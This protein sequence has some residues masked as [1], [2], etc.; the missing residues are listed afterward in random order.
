MIKPDLVPAFCKYF[1]IDLPK[2]SRINLERYHLMRKEWNQWFGHAEQT[3]ER[4]RDFYAQSEFLPYGLLHCAMGEI[5]ASE[6]AWVR[7]QLEK[8]EAKSILDY[9]CG[10]AIATGPLS[11]EM[12]VTLADI[13]GRHWPLVKQLYPA[14]QF[15]EIGG[16][17]ESLGKYDAVVCREVFEHCKQPLETAK[18]VLGCVAE[19][20][21]AILSWTFSGS[22]SLPLHLEANSGTDFERDFKQSL[23]D[24][25]WKATGQHGL[26]LRAWKRA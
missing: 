4:L 26:T 22:V 23:A 21:V 9:G 7:E 24:L 15:V 3:E 2:L 6:T 12:T 18:K 16:D 11:D 19:A 5:G 20:G 8:V 10:F 14:A 1:G 17:Q 13:P 25:G